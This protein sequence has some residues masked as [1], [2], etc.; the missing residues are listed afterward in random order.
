MRYYELRETPAD[1]LAWTGHYS[2][3]RRWM[4]P[5]I[6]CPSCGIWSFGYSLP[7]VDLSACPERAELIPQMPVSPE[8]CARLIEYARPYAPD[9]PLGPGES[10][11]PLVGT[12]SGRFGP[13]HACPTWEL[14]V[15]EDALRSLQA[16]GLRGLLPV[17]TRISQRSKS[18]QPLI[19]LYAPRVARFMTSGL[20]PP[21][22]V[23]ARPAR[24]T[25]RLDA[26]D[27]ASIPDVDV[28]GAENSIVP[29]VSERFVEVAL[30]LGPSDVIYREVPV[31]DLRG[32]APAAQIH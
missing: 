26:L 2:A 16:A 23:C 29:I 7:L 14:V 9:A 8:H 28:F 4:I 3:G 1:K 15:R 24:R 22:A 6:N 21:C 27:P 19:E 13:I 12:S 30:T 31:Q 17:P 32:D 10:L 25:G 18:A 11:G 5:S 20:Q